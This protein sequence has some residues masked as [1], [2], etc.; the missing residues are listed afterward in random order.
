MA[1][2][3]C[4]DSLA[5]P[6]SMPDAAAASRSGR[7][8]RTRSVPLVRIDK[9]QLSQQLRCSGEQLISIRTSEHFRGIARLGIPS[10]FELTFQNTI[11]YASDASTRGG[12]RHKP[13]KELIVGPKRELRGLPVAGHS[14]LDLATRSPCATERSFN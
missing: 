6:S 8:S 12:G 2:A 1:A 14:L 10:D 4:I 5:S 3:T 13:K 7:A 9:V 11:S